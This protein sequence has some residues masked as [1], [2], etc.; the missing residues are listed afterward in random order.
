VPPAL[1]SI[2]LWVERVFCAGGTLCLAVIVVLIVGDIIGRQIGHPITF[3]VELSSYLQVMMMFLAGA[4]TLRLGLH[5]RAEAF[6]RR[7]PPRTRLFFWLA[8]EF[9]ALILAIIITISC[10]ELAIGSYTSKITSTSLL[11]M[12]LGIPQLILFVGM[13]LFTIESLALIIRRIHKHQR[14]VAD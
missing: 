10:W 4:Y 7:L 11:K 14:G 9:F 13:S 8:T 5:I 12:P 3:S 6:T 2:L 1:D